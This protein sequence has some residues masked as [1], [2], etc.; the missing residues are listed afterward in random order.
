MKLIPNKY[1]QY[2]I[3]LTLPRAKS[4]ADFYIAS[5]KPADS[6]QLDDIYLEKILNPFHFFEGNILS[7]A[8]TNCDMDEIS[9]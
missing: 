1:I 5:L 9:Q 6:S 4:K 8:L 3:G 2:V 7:Y